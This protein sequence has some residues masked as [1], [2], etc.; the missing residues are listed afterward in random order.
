MVGVNFAQ[1]EVV[2][3]TDTADTLR[4]CINLLRAATAK[5]TQDPRSREAS[6]GSADVPTT[7]EYMNKAAQQVAWK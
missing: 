2:R 4:R 5:K 1:Y 3:P 6:S 7:L